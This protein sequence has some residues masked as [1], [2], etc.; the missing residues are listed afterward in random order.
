MV[1]LK[2]SMNQR[3]AGRFE[4]FMGS[5]EAKNILKQNGFEVPDSGN[6]PH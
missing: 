3:A 2:S 1:V 6:A 4:T 5:D